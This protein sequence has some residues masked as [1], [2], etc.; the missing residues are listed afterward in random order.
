MDVD[1]ELIKMS[2][3]GQLV[4]PQRIRQKQHFNPSDRFVA[5]EVNDGIVFK[6]VKI[7]NVKVEFK[8]L[9]KEI[10]RQFKEKGVKEGDVEEAVRW[11]RKG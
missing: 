4:V 9:S 11:S 3:K 8:A 6:R 1:Q 10:S 7:P 2:S 5:F